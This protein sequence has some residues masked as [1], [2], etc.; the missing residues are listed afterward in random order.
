MMK[1]AFYFTE[2]VPF[3]PNAPNVRKF[4]V[5]VFPSFP[6]QQEGPGNN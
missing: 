4:H 5:F 6:L 3:V 2:K 1:N